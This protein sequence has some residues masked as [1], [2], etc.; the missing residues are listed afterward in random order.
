M[1]PAWQPTPPCSVPIVTV[2]RHSVS[3]GQDLQGSTCQKQFTVLTQAE[4]PAV[5][6][7]IRENPPN[8]AAVW[9]TA[10]LTATVPAV[11]VR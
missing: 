9:L 1:V 8:A 6:I 4:G 2:A 10:R 11:T 5:T 3:T 7:A